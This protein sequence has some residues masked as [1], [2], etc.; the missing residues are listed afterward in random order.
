MKIARTLLITAAAIILT[1]CSRS[2]S[3]KTRNEKEAEFKN[4]FGFSPTS[5][6]VSIEYA[7]LY[8]RE[9]MDGAYEQWISFTY[10]A[11]TYR[12]ILGS[13]YKSTGSESFPTGDYFPAWWPKSVVATFFTRG[14]EDTPEAEDFSFRECLWYD[15]SAGQVFYNKS[16]WN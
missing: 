3:A 15:E 5:A 9:V 1:S 12:K 11:E 2:T 6:I 7:D 10:D 16:Y 13:G 14:H 4:T 8:N